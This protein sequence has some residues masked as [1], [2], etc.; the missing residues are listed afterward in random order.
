MFP[1]NLLVPLDG[2]DLAEAALPIA[3]LLAMTIGAE[4]TLV[5]VVLPDN[6][7]GSSRWPAE[8]LQRCAAQQHAAGVTAHT[9]MRLGEPA[10]EILALA[11]EIPADLLVMATHGRSGLDRVV[12]GSVAERVTRRSRIPVILLRPDHHPAVGF[13]TLLVPVDGST[14]GAVALDT[15]VPLARTSHARLVLV[16]A[17]VPLPL[18]LYEPTLGVDTG[19]LIDP[20]WD[21]DERKAAEMYASALADRLVGTGVVAEGRGVS[22]EPG[23][24]IVSVADEIDAD[25][26]V[27]STHGRGLPLRAVLGSVADDVVRRSRRPVL[28]VHRPSSEGHAPQT[29]QGIASGSR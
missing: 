25:L 14:G 16:R 27:M 26:I 22:G 1:K 23:P 2:T 3:R 12:L 28:L 11:D 20:M 13:R 19:P 24:A 5:R 18:W 8:Y 21:E 29:S 9:T 7:P 17:T 4:L 15:A 10:E 6:E